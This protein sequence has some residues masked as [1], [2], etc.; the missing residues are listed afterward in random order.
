MTQIQAD[1][2]QTPGLVRQLSLFDA[3]MIGDAD[4]VLVSSLL[5]SGNATVIGVKG[6]LAEHGLSVRY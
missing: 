5:H 1:R 4:A 3:A 2:G 6:Y